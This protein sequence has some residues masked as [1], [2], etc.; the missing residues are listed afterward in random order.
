M[1]YRCRVVLNFAT[2]RTNRLMFPL[3][4]G[5]RACVLV[6]TVGRSCK[7]QKLYILRN[8]SVMDNTQQVTI[9]PSN[10]SY[11]TSAPN[12]AEGNQPAEDHRDAFRLFS[13][14]PRSFFR[15]DATHG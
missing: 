8:V 9:R 6:S 14:G 10:P 11:R 13:E 12:P 5:L 4:R 1:P 2:T 15:R 7:G 3:A